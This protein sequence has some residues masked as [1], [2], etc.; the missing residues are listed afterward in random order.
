MKKK[1][2]KTE[3]DYIPSNGQNTYNARCIE[4]ELDRNKSVSTIGK[5][6]SNNVLQFTATHFYVEH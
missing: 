3:S 6:N 1:K 5:L 2:K 4:V